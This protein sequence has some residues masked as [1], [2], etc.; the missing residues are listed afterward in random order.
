MTGRKAVI[1]PS[2][3]R[4]SASALD[5]VDTELMGS[6]TA[7]QRTGFTQ[8]E[9]ETITAISELA[10]QFGKTGAGGLPRSDTIMVAVDAN[11]EPIS[12]A[13]IAPTGRQRE[14]AA[15]VGDPAALAHSPGRGT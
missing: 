11:R 7:L 2:L 1:G 10:A 3:P 15:A 5:R 13:G 9:I 12:L 4:P 14:L 8:K 6:R